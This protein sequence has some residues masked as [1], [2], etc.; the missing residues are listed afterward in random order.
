MGSRQPA[1]AAELLKVR[2]RR[3]RVHGGG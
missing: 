2:E 3:A 1:L